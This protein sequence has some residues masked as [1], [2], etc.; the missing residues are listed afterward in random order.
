V[1]EFARILESSIEKNDHILGFSSECLE[2]ELF[3]E[4]ENALLYYL[5][6]KKTSVVGHIGL[7]ILYNLLHKYV[8][9]IRHVETARMLVDISQDSIEEVY[10]N[11]L[12]LFHL[13]CQKKY[14]EDQ[15]KEQEVLEVDSK[16]SDY[17]RALRQII[18]AKSRQEKLNAEMQALKIHN[19]M[20]SD[21]WGRDYFRDRPYSEKKY[22]F[23]EKSHRDRPGEFEKYY[24]RNLVPEEPFITKDTEIL[25]F[26]SCFATNI[27]EYL[28]A[29]QYSINTNHKT[30]NVNRVW[31]SDGMV[32]TY[33]L[34]Q[35]FEW[36]FE[37]K[38]FSEPLWSDDE[39]KILEYATEVKEATRR[40]FMRS[41]VFIITLGLSEVWYNK[42]SDEVLMRL[43]PRK[44]FDREIYDFRVVN[45]DEN[46][47]NL[48]KIY[49]SIRR[50]KKEAT[51]IFTLSPI[52]MHRTFRPIPCVSADSVSKSILRVAVDELMRRHI[53]DP[54]LYY[55][56]SFEI[57]KYYFIDPYELDN[58]HITEEAH[59][60]IM[61]KFAHYFL[62]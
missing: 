17:E 29:K 33:T 30:G 45:V 60:F 24:L 2:K 36:A 25:A 43:I 31:L 57:V 16:R 7:S 6:Q 46:L 5:K 34:L 55:F 42:I 23:P 56:P 59:D 1:F 52:P 22:L 53:E 18:E 40:V 14:R 4:A 27:T 28:R 62:K 9:A 54:D 50:I 49:Q 11:D 21:D 35:Q 44:H 41:E 58:A 20:H 48:E 47:I 13:S 37:G 10:L 51:I 32:N 8:L 15:I 12:K 38:E 3:H 19:S 26:G 39:N 61:G